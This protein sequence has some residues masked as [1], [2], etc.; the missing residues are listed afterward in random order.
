M[1]PK[2][3]DSKL[4]IDIGKELYKGLS[5]DKFFRLL[6]VEQAVELLKNSNPNP[7]GV[8]EVINNI[9]KFYTNG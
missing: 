1:L 5:E 8:D 6:A 4:P 7:K 9:Y 2:V 3:T